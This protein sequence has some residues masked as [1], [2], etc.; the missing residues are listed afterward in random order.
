[1]PQ[2][3][4]F[5]IVKSSYIEISGSC[6]NTSLP[7]QTAFLSKP[8]NMRFSNWVWNSDK[9]FYRCC[10]PAPF[11]PREKS[12][13]YSLRNVVDGCETPNFLLRFLYGYDFFGSKL[14]ALGLLNPW[15]HLQLLFWCFNYD[16]LMTMLF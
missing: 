7:F 1:M 4:M 5:S 10:F 9:H 16:I 6:I 13:L 8:R 15:I 3:L 11:A 2:K 14:I 12:H